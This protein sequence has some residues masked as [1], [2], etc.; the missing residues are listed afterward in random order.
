MPSNTRMDFCAHVRSR[1]RHGISP[2]YHDLSFVQP[3]RTC[4][5]SISSARTLAEGN[6][7]YRIIETMNW[8]RFLAAFCGKRQKP[9]AALADRRRG[10]DPCGGSDPRR[11]RLRVAALGHTDDEAAET[12]RRHVHPDRRSIAVQDAEIIAI[13]VPAS[14]QHSVPGQAD[15]RHPPPPEAQPRLRIGRRRDDG[16]EAD[17]DV[18]VET[19]ELLAQSEMDY[20]VLVVDN[21]LGHL[22]EDTRVGPAQCQ[23]A[24]VAAAGLGIQPPRP[25][26]QADPVAARVSCP[27]GLPATEVSAGDGG[28][29][30]A[31]GSR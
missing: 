3:R 13:T 9:A 27:G 25:A 29:G 10:G 30:G 26:R 2:A 28:R 23:H 15:P 1:G 6:V 20:Q 8:M 14:P 5:T 24:A 19:P 12:S 4:T 22:V 17:P 16:G 18:T 21:Q 7:R 11:F 31:G